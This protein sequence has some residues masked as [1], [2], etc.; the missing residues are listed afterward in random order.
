MR[1]F[2]DSMGSEIVSFD[3]SFFVKLVF[4]LLSYLKTTINDFNYRLKNIFSTLC[5]NFVFPKIK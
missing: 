3:S 5:K 2:T 4:I 1:F